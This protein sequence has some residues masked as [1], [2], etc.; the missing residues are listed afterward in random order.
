MAS[1]K[2]RKSRKCRKSAAS[3]KFRTRWRHVLLIDQRIRA[4]KAPNCRQLAKE[5]EVSRR[6]VLRDIDFL[7]YDLGAPVEYDPARRGYVYTQPNWVM[8]SVRITEGE[9]FALM[10]A[11]KAL[12]AYAGT[13][14]AERL[15]RVFD[16][17]TASLPERIEVAPQELLPRVAFDAGAPSIVDPAILAT[18]STAVTANQTLRLSYHPLDR[19][20]PREYV[21][22]PYVLR[23]ARGAWYLAGRDHRSGHVPLFNLSRVRRAEP[24]GRTFDYD[25]AEFAPD[26]YFGRTFAVFHS[27]EHHRVV[28]EFSGAAARLVRERQWHASQ[29]LRDLPRGRVQFEAE[30]SHLWDIWPWVLSWG[31]EAK[32]LEPEELVR[33]VADQAAGTARL[34]AEGNQ[35]AAGGT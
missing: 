20:E 25:E 16:R 17:I 8:P 13:P 28:I 21:V 27:P 14:W 22:D 6:T 30:V 11:E 19:D 7:R 18:V 35:P 34:Y 31:A 23:Q 26:A 33:L 12:D 4:G 2:T 1:R 29:R 10:V 5:L 15:R 3:P 9:L 24:T 32:V